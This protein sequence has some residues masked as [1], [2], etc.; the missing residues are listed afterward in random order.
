MFGPSSARLLAMFV[1]GIAQGWLAQAQ[2]VRQA[3][4]RFLDSQTLRLLAVK[5]AQIYRILVKL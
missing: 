4:F 5:E 2:G 3:V 1:A